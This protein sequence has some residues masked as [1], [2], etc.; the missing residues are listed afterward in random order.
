MA[1]NYAADVDT[2]FREKFARSAT[3]FE[4]GKALF[5]S[6]VTH[7]G[8]YLEPFPVYVTE[9]HGSRKTSVEGHSIIDYWVGHGSLLLGHGHP[10]VVEAVQKQMALGTHFSACHELELEWAE[11]VQRM[12]P[13]A[14]RIRFTNSGTEATLMAIRVARIVTARE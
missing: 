12:V 11:R 7:D 13:S 8:R 10:A 3:L 14:E 9:A 6:G 4:R 1:E 5:P 2:A